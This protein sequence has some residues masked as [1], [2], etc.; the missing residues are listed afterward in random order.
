MAS[1]I[2]ASQFSVQIIET[3]TLDGV[4]RGSKVTS[5]ESSVS[6]V[7]RRTMQV[8]HDTNGTSIMKFNSTPATGTYD[9]DTFKYLRITNLDADDSLILQLVESG[10]SHYTELLVG[11]K[12]SFILN[13]LAIDNQAD[14]DNGVLTG[15]SAQY[16]DE[17][18]GKSTGSAVVEIEYIV[19]N[20]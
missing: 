10:G 16:I 18:I 5:I 9:L 4:K 2:T 8:T 15:G 1:T 11:P 6:E 12:K 19:I 13:S 17:I 14:I 7:A 3:L 20:T